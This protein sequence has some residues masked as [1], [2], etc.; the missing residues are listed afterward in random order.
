VVASVI[1]LVVARILMKAASQYES[2]TIEADARHLMTDVF[3][4]A[5]VVG[6]VILVSVT[7]WQRLD[8]IIALLVA[9]NII[10]AGYSL[11]RRSM[12]GLLDTALPREEIGII[13]GVLDR[14]REPGTIDM[15]ALRT[16]QAASRRF[17]SVHIIVPGDWSIERGH[18]LAEDI[19]RDIRGS[20]SSITVFTHLEPDT[21]PTTWE[22]TGLDRPAQ[23]PEVRNHVIAG[24]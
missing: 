4:S 11:I 17:A 16:R 22:D 2:I 18:A 9:V 7:G 13:E 15:H 3:T 24:V 20:L 8:P 6:A 1:N 5:G 10:L 14:Y 23:S 21:D 19:E 12:L